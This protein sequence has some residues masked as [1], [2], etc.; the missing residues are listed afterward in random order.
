MRESLTLSVGACLPRTHSPAQPRSR[1][2]QHRTTRDYQRVAARRAGHRSHHP[3][4]RPAV[5]RPRRCCPGGRCNPMG[6]CALTSRNGRRAVNPL[7]CARSPRVRREPSLLVPL[8]LDVVCGDARVQEV[9]QCSS[10]R[11]RICQE[12]ARREHRRRAVATERERSHDPRQ[13]RHASSAL[14]TSFLR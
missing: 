8:S 13:T 7:R 6:A 4:A 5:R 2:P 14:A 10:V 1:G 11:F 9:C 3:S 12:R